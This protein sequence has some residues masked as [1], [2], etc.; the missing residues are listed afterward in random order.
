MRPCFWCWAREIDATV[1]WFF[2]RA[3]RPAPSPRR[4]GTRTVWATVQELHTK[5]IRRP[6]R[7]RQPGRVGAQRHR[8]C[9][10]AHELGRRRRPSRR[11][12]QEWRVQPRSTR[13]PTTPSPGII[14]EAREV[15]SQRPQIARHQV[16]SSSLDR[17]YRW[18]S[19]GHACDHLVHWPPASAK[20][21]LACRRTCAGR[22]GP[23]RLPARRRQSAPRLS[24]TTSAFGGDRPR[25]SGRVGH[26]TRLLADAV[27][28]R[29]R[30]WCRA[31]ALD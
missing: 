21:T 9:H 4:A 19:T 13:Y 7:A 15:A 17:E 10:T 6:R 24:P 11:Q 16:A 29:W 27:W 2:D 18:N 31:A 30:R 12:P 1:C 25:T 20:S 23:G 8:R 3:A 26:L 22:I 5:S 28:S 14:V